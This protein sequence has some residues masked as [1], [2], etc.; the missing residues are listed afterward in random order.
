M[1]KVLIFSLAYY[2]RHVSGAEAA[3]KEITDRI[4]DI[5]FHMVTLRFD[6]SDVKQEKIGRVDVHRVGN[7][8]YFGKIVFPL[9]AVLEAHR[10]HRQHQ[11]DAIWAMMTYM[12]LPTAIFKIFGV[13]I[14]HILTLQDGD[15]YEKVFSRT[16]IKPFLFFIDKGFREAQVIQ[17]ISTY[18][19][20]WPAR[21]GFR[22]EVEIIYNGANPRDIAD[23]VSQEESEKMKQKLGK[24]KGEVYLVNTARLEYQK[25]QDD[26]IRAL[27]MLPVHVKFLIVGGGSD[28]KML[29]DLVEELDL[30][31]R[32]MFTGQVD[33]S[34][35]TAYRKAS[36]IFVAPSRSEGLGNA[37]LSAMASRLPV[38][39]TQ[40]GGLSEFIFDEKRDPQKPTTAWAV[41]KDS[42]EQI[43]AAVKE[44][45]TNPEQVKRVTETAR[46]MVVE[47][48]NWDMI[49]QQMRERV[50][51]KV[52]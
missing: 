26:V 18:L 50:F 44:I 2:P 41:E 46:A 28:E 8:S 4:S 19:A 39:A 35:V 10:L 20:A 47:K 6:A 7:G 13:S 12:L 40:E 3:V 42:P 36:D 30:Q 37:F 34:E 5:E 32:V 17:A 25:A 29:K 22:G 16:R 14:P 11:F 43:A 23:A 38:V 15:P 24:Q 27:P 45:M 31:S 1:K 21:R 48:Y 51:G 33:R 9:S 49:A 52:L